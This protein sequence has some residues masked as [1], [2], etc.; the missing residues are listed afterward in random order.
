MD[1]ILVKD[2][3]S[4]LFDRISLAYYESRKKRFS[5]S[6]DEKKES[7]IK[8]HYVIVKVDGEEIYDSKKNGVMNDELYNSLL[9]YGVIQE[10][11]DDN[12]GKRKKKNR[13]KDSNT[14]PVIVNVSAKLTCVSETG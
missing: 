7:F 12:K 13:K 10:A 9:A 5:Q 1:N 8:Q 2:W 6:L 11:L 14:S 4:I 3:G